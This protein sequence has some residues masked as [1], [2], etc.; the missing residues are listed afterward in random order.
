[1]NAPVK[2]IN[3]KEPH[4]FSGV[5]KPAKWCDYCYKHES[6][7]IHNIPPLVAQSDPGD[8][9]MAS[10][11][12]TGGQD[13][14]RMIDEKDCK[15]TLLT[16]NRQSCLTC[17]IPISVDDL[18]NRP[19]G[20]V[21]EGENPKD[22]L[23][24]K[25][26]PLELVPAAGVVHEAMAFKNGGIKYGPYNWRLKRVKALVY[27]GAAKRHLDRYLDGEDYETD[28]VT[29]VCVHNLGAARACIGI[30]L[31]AMETGNLDDNRPPKGAAP[32]L[33]DEMTEK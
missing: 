16:K 7:P 3:A 27:I 2:F 12:V 29:G 32:R 1:M 6:D 30:L 17:G 11:S 20:Q 9:T 26:P 5:Y 8:E 21:D 10:N 24:I 18:L 13:F 23:G 4:E 25:K 31:D 28:P 15:H 19:Y 14:V 33:I 22:R